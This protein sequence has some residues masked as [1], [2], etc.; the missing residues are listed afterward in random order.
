MLM[1]RSAANGL[2]IANDQRRAARAAPVREGSNDTP[3]C[4]WIYRGFE[5]PPNI[6]TSS[7]VGTQ[8]AGAL[9]GCLQ[10]RAQ[11]ICRAFR[12]RNHG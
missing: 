6:P 2:R 7:R 9:E 3:R 10:A 4:P 11:E 1:T 8:D 5:E 12:Q